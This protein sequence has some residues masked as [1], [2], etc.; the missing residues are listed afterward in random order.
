MHVFKQGILAS[1]LALL[2]AQTVCAEETS[3]AP[4]AA[5]ATD[6]TTAPQ[7]TESQA[8]AAKAETPRLEN[9]QRLFHIVATGGLSMGGDT[10]A[11]AYYN[12]GDSED[13]K[14]GGLVYFAGG[15]GLDIPDTPITLQLAAGYQVNDSSADNGKMTFDRTTLDAQ[16]FF[17]QGNHRFGVGAVQ[18]SSPEYIGKMDGQPDD[19][20]EFDDASGFSLE[21]NYLP[22]II[23]WPFKEGRAGFSLRYVKIDYKVKTYNGMTVLNP[24]PIDGSHVAAGL[25]LYL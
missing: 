25:Y 23:N 5:A 12:N 22:A 1:T 15:L 17:R 14:A 10:I 7:T 8:P 16:V 21:Y 19:R 3:T 4:A 20:A 2:L 24:K 18:H 13:L 6:V 9:S 11:T